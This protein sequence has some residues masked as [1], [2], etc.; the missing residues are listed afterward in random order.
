MNSFGI[1]NNNNNTSHVDVLTGLG[2]TEIDR[3]GTGS[4]TLT[5][6]NYNDEELTLSENTISSSDKQLNN[7]RATRKKVNI[8][9]Y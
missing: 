5:N 3:S 4:A 2:I 8:Y 6:H 1:N 9:L 7:I